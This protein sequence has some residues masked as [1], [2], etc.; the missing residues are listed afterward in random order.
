MLNLASAHDCKYEYAYKAAAAL[1]I[2]LLRVGGIW[3]RLGWAH[4][5]WCIALLQVAQNF[6][7]KALA[8]SNFFYR[9]APRQFNGAS[10]W[11]ILVGAS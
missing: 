2:Q 7:N 3:R 8:L 6:F 9:I 1:S 4:A 10:S 11:L 5:P